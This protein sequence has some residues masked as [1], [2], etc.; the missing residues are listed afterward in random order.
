MA[1]YMRKRINIQLAFFT[2]FVILTIVFVMSFLFYDILKKQVFEDLRINANVIKNVDETRFNDF[3]DL[4]I[5]KIS[6]NGIV[7]FDNNA[8][9]GDM[10]N[11]AYRPEVE[12]AQKIGFGQCARRSRTLNHNTFYYAV[13]LDDGAVLRVAYSAANAFGIITNA[14]PVIIMIVCVMLIIIVICAR[15][16]TVSLIRPIVNMTKYIDDVGYVEPV[17]NEL[18]PF[19]NTIREQHENILKSSKIRQDFTANVSHE[20]KTPLT[21]ISGYAEL[22]ENGLCNTTEVVRFSHE[23]RH[24]SQR[25]LSLINDIIKL[26]ELDSIKEEIAFEVFDLC[27]VVSKCVDVIKVNAQRNDVLI[28]FESNGSKVELNANREMITE[29]VY[30]LCDNAIRYNNK[31][32]RV[33]VYIECINDKKRLVVSDTGIGIP[34]EHQER[35]FERFYRVDKSR[36]RQSGGTGLGLSIVKHI[37]AL[38]NATIQLNSSPGKGTEIIITF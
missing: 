10:D 25:L 26:S 31:K 7:L 18:L 29:L 17:Y 34:P 19:I 6:S 16:M 2:L 33:D 9:V 3:K 8:N 14:V 4:R 35:I 5:T 15:F 23:I 36:S 1:V 22:I 32:G 28:K 20:L 21:A 11:H 37:A 12:E 24:N 38:H 27:D 30:N 13:K